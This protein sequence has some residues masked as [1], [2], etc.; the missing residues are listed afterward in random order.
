MA[1]PLN[2]VP[3]IAEPL[4]C[5]APLFHAALGE[6]M[7]KLQLGG[8]TV[9][10]SRWQH[11]LSADLDFF[12]HSPSPKDNHTLLSTIRKSVEQNADEY[13]LTD[14]DVA[15]RHLSFV[16]IRTRTSIFTT[17]PLTD[18]RPEQHE[19]TTRI[20]LEAT[21]EILAKKL[22]GRILGNGDFT[23]RDF[24]DFCVAAQREPEALNAVL[25]TLG[26]ERVLIYSELSNKYRYSSRRCQLSNAC[27]WRSTGKI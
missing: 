16:T 15:S 20:Q 3:N 5:L 8:D 9:L 12:L 10:A 19:T 4:R 26:N 13:S 11:R 17:P 1:A 23:K 21:E 6:N 27:G 2:I 18:K 22:H 7:D 24:Y 14:I 25:K